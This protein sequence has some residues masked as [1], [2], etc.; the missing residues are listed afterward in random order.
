MAAMGLLQFVRALR[1]Q[2]GRL[3]SACFV[4][5]LLATLFVNWP[6]SKPSISNAWNAMAYSAARQGFT[7]EADRIS[8]RGHGVKTFDSGDK[9]IFKVGPGAVSPKNRSN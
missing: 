7:E 2:R 9:G 3:V 1:W 5:W 8:K 6:V 4:T